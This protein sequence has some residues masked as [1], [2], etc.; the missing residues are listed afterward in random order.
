MLSRTSTPTGRRSRRRHQR[1]RRRASCRRRKRQVP[2]KSGGKVTKAATKPSAKAQK[3]M[4]PLG[5]K[6]NCAP[7][8]EK[9]GQMQ[10]EIKDALD[11]LMD[12]LA[13]VTL[14]CNT[15]EANFRSDIANAEHLVSQFTSKMTE[16]TG[17]LQN[18]MYEGV[19][20][21]VERHEVCSEMRTEYGKCYKTIKALEQELCGI[22]IIRFATHQKMVPEIKEP[23]FQDCIV[24]GWT[25][26]ECSKTCLD[27][28]GMG[29][30]E[31]FTREV[32]IAPNKIGAACPPLTWERAC[33]EVSCPLHC[34]LDIW[35]PWGDCTKDCGGGSQ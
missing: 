28:N 27:E 26:G 34:K 5:T 4:C 1:R 21:E 10:G 12:H 6:P 3:S 13:A 17:L 25:P 30:I 33:G 20:K 14:E 31:I 9:L 35:G 7:L 22:I 18:S 23:D 15:I 19:Q 11:K 32:T 24:S 16:D 8:L 2:N 29:G